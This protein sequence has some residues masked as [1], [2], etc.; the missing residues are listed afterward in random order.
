MIMK[1]LIIASNNAGKIKEYKQALS[2]KNIKI[3]TL[4]DFESIEIEEPYSSFEENALLKAKTIFDKFK[5][6]C[7]SDDSGLV[8]EALPEELGVKSKRF[9]ISN[10]DEDNI[11]LL[12]EKLQNQHNRNA[13]FICVIC[14]Y[15]SPTDIRVYQGKTQ[16]L[17]IDQQRGNNGFG[18][19][20]VFL[21]PQYNKTFAELTINEKQE[22]SH[23]GKA[24]KLMI[25]DLKNENIDI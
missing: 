9:S 11:K 7:L 6:P 13:Y 21:V 10:T 23:R 3:L 5:I 4:N 17:I 16:G 24:I 15:L 18:Y 8:V 25:E 14:L 1:E 19:D 12:L 20:P 2:N 22:L